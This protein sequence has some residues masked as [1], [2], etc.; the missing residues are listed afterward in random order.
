MHNVPNIIPDPNI[1]QPAQVTSDASTRPYI[2]AE[3]IPTVQLPK[4]L[5]DLLKMLHKYHG[6][7]NLPLSQMH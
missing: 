6:V 2:N 3:M 7:I 5:S 4:D 1:S